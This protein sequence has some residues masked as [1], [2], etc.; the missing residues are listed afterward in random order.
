[1]PKPAKHE[2]HLPPATILH[3]PLDTAEETVSAEKDR[4]MAQTGGYCFAAARL[5]K[6]DVS[7]EIE[8][9]KESRMASRA[10]SIRF[11]RCDDRRIYRWFGLRT[12]CAIDENSGFQIIDRGAG[13]HETACFVLPCRHCSFCSSRS[14]IRCINASSRSGS[15]SL[16]AWSQSFC[17]SSRVSPCT[18][19]HLPSSTYL[20]Y[21]TNRRRQNHEI[22]L[23]A[24]PVWFGFT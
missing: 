17:H 12:F 13:N 5:P 20:L 1:M 18:V 2:S 24:H 4:E 23:P 7:C 9:G 15:C 14:L 10:R 22:P 11:V 21:S 8:H 3:L 16:A 19:A 6:E